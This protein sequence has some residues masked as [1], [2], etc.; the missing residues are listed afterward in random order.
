MTADMGGFD[1]ILGTTMEHYRR[2]LLAQITAPTMFDE[3]GS[4]V[5]DEQRGYWRPIT[6]SPHA[7]PQIEIIPGWFRTERWIEQHIRQPWTEA[8]LRLREAKSILRHGIPERD[9]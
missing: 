8:R 4:K 3:P 9:D 5:F 2:G 7:W 1:K 6:H